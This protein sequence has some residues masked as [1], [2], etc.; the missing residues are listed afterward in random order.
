MLKY[1]IIVAGGKGERMGAAV[2]KQFVPV[3]GLPVLM[4]TIRAFVEAYKDISIILVLPKESLELWVGLLHKH[5]FTIPCRLAI[6]G[7]TRFQSVKNG[8]DLI[9]IDADDGDYG[10]VAVHDGVRPFVSPGLIRRCYKTANSQGSAVPVVPVV[11][12][13]RQLTADGRSQM[14]SRNDY[15]LVQT[16]QV[17]RTYL[18]KEAY[19]QPFREEF[20]DDASVV[21]ALG[22]EV[23][24]VDG[25]RTNIKLTTPSDMAFA[26]YL[27]R[28]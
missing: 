5:N 12:T 26:E 14:V 9:P 10:V 27:C 11:E 2:P 23:T 8:L 15:R 18:L 24:L 16:P 4:R 1:A 3:D 17:F 13:M 28:A 25:E 22:H 21:E 20:T 19:R 6:G 7:T